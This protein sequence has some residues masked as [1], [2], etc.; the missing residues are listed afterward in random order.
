MAILSTALVALGVV[1]AILLAPDQ[2]G[3][4]GGVTDRAPVAA[5]TSTL[6]AV[7]LSTC[8]AISRVTR[9]TTD[10]TVSTALLI[11]P[12]RGRLLLARCVAQ[13]MVGALTAGLAAAC[14]T[15]VT[16][17]WPGN[18]GSL[19]GFYAGLVGAAIATGAVTGVLA[20]LL[21]TALRHGVAALGSLMIV[22]AALPAGLVVAQSSLPDHLAQL[23][24]GLSPIFPGPLTIRSLTVPYGLSAG[25]RPYLVG[26]LVGLVI[27]CLVLAGPA[28]ARFRRES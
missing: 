20:C 7:I 8:Y 19:G 28:L 1:C 15:L 24:R 21:S 27:W 6:V 22:G 16:A 3:V 12:A 26:A 18:L 25:S 13:A 14:A 17:T 5:M 4:L 10:G 9:E 2:T 23:A 11:V